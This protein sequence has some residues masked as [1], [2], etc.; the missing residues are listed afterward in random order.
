[1]SAAEFGP[2]DFLCPLRQI[3]VGLEGREER[4]VPY[5]V[6]GVS[7]VPGELKDWPDLR[8]G[9]PVHQVMQFLTPRAHAASIRAAG[10]AG[11]ESE[12]RA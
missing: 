3:W 4:Q 1:M 10:A 8:L 9:K 6:R 12:T 5:A 11:G 2:Q 7:S